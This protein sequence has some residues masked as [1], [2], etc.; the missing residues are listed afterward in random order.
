MPY[1][2]Q[3]EKKIK[4][5]GRASSSSPGLASLADLEDIR[6]VAHLRRSSAPYLLPKAYVEKL[7][8]R[9]EVVQAY[10][11]RG[12]GTSVSARTLIENLDRL[13]IEVNEDS[14]PHNPET[15]EDNEDASSPGDSCDALEMGARQSQLGYSAHVDSASTTPGHDT[16][17]LSRRRLAA[18]KPT[19]DCHLLLPPTPDFDKLGHSDTV[20][21]PE[22]TTSPS[23]AALAV[24]RS[25]TAL[26]RLAIPA[27]SP[28]GANAMPIT[29]TG[30]ILQELRTPPNAPRQTV[31]RIRPASLLTSLLSNSIRDNE[32][33]VTS[34]YPFTPMNDKPMTPMQVS[35]GP[36]T[37]QP[38]DGVSPSASTSGSSQAGFYV[39]SGNPKPPTKASRRV[40]LHE[41]A[42]SPPSPFSLDHAQPS[43]DLAS[44]M[45]LLTPRSPRFSRVL[46]SPV[47]QLS[48]PGYFN[49]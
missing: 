42:L 2:R 47:I 16:P 40:S 35:P 39:A 36:D 7:A 38:R 21:S 1:K 37:T 13:C 5:R 20:K 26:T 33:D 34:P 10:V 46:H 23:D 6:Q 4:G 17:S 29:P 31:S 49:V 41:A 27:A 11:R 15:P 18:N 44:P 12:S 8:R 45:A 14:L 30:Q 28:S 32:K 48:S 25:R 3:K 9:P 43:H 24:K 19:L 22:I